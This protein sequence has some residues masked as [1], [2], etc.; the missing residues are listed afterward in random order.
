MTLLMTSLI[1][2][3]A[4][5]GEATFGFAGGMISVPLLT[6]LLGVKDAVTVVL[7]FQL[8]MGLLLFSS[9]SEIDRA[10]TKRAI[11]GVFIG[12]TAG[13]FLLG[14]VSSVALKI[15]LLLVIVGY[16]LR[17]LLAPTAKISILGPAG[18]GL[19]GGV[20]GGF[21]QGLVGMG[22]PPFLIYLNSLGIPKNTF[23]ATII[24]LLFLSNI[25]RLPVSFAS[26]LFNEVVQEVV[27]CALPLF[28]L[29]I[30]VGHRL[31]GKVSD[32]LY[33]ICVYGVLVASAFSIGI[34]AVW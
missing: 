14:S 24:L 3:A 26:G 8:L 20:G 33:R 34:Q 15:T 4:F 23:R 10:S 12:T 18:A 17:E 32:K 22:G 21:L 1:I 19:V 13:T 16:L 28:F 30:F 7:A 25:V 27:L 6:L 29:A 9:W 2:G 11:L 5:L 31:H